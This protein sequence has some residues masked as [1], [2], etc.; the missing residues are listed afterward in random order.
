MLGLLFLLDEDLLSQN[1]LEI[2][3]LM[4]LILKYFQKL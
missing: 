3:L 1:Y 2:F 4:L